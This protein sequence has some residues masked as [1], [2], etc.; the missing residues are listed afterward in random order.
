[1]GMSYGGW[2]TSQYALR[3]QDRL[4]KIILLA[5][6]ATLLPLR[7]LWIMRA[8]LCMLPHRYFLKNFMY[9]LLADLAQKDEAGRITIEEEVDAAYMALK[10][11]KPNRLVAPTVLTDEELKSLKVPTLYLVG[12]HERIYSAQK[13]VQRLHR[14]APHIHAEVIRNAGHDLTFVQAE[15]VN[16]KVLEFLI[17]RVE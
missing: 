1:M 15:I 13:A 3:F 12:E 11:F 5:P 16:R 10:C 14:V 17:N 8:L 9:W 2:L 6:G 7:Y 4:D